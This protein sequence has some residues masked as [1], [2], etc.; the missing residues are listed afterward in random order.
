M[1]R[2]RRRPIPTPL[3]WVLALVCA[4]T[5]GA[6]PQ[7]SQ[8]APATNH[9]SF[10]KQVRPILTDNCYLC[11]GPDKGTRKAGLRLDDRDAALAG[12]KGRRAIVPGNSAASELF[13]R[14]SSHDPNYRM[15]QRE[16]GRSLT[17]KQIALLK[18]WI[19]QGALYEPHWAYVAPQKKTPPPV[20]QTAWVRNPVDAFILSEL[21]KEGL[22]PSPEAD[23][24]TLI[25][26]LNFDLTGLPP[27][28]AEVDAFLA[29]TAPD[30]YEHLVDRLLASPHYG[31]RMAVY[32]LDLVRFA[33]TVGY[34]GDQNVDVWPFRDYVIRAFNDNLPFDQFTREQLAGDLLPNATAQ[35]KV[36]SAYNRLNMV[37]REGGAQAKEY[38]AKY[39]AD[40]VRTT[41]SVWLGSTLGCA[42]CHDHKFDPFSTKDF[43][44]FAAFFADV[45]E[46]GVYESAAFYAA[47]PPVMR[48]SNA[49]QDKKLAALTTQLQQTEKEQALLLDAS[50]DL[51]DLPLAEAQQKVAAVLGVD[52]TGLAKQVADWEQAALERVQRGQE[53]ELAVIIEDDVRGGKKDGQWN[54]VEKVADKPTHSGRR[55]REQ[56]GDGVVQHFAEGFARPQKLQKQDRLYAYVYLDPQNPPAEIMLQWDTGGSQWAHRAY[57]G[58]DLIP[59]GAIGSDAPDHRRL[60]DLPATGQ[61][62]RLEADL[63]KLGFKPGQQLHGLAFTQHGGHVWWDDAG[64]F[65]KDLPPEDVIAVLNKPAASRTENDR[66]LLLAEFFDEVPLKAAVDRHAAAK[67]E[68]AAFDETLP[69]CVITESVEPRVTHVLPRGNWMDDSG[70]V[71]SPAVPHSLPQPDNSTQRRLTRLDL[72]NWLVSRENPLTA[73]VVVN[74]LW[75]LYFGNGLSKVLDDLGTRGEWPRHLDLLDWLAAEFMDGPDGLRSPLGTT[76]RA[77]AAISLSSSG[78]EGR[79]EEVVSTNS[80]LQSTGSHWDLKHMVRLLVTS[81][82]YRQSS[83][84]TEHLKEFDPFNRFHARQS[85]WRLDAE[86]V[87]DNALAISGLLVPTVGGASVNPYQPSDYY[88]ELNFPKRTYTPDKGENQYRRGLY[89][90]W[91]RTFLHPSLG[92]FDAPSREECTAE[93]NVSNSPLQA[94]T[95]LNDPTYVEASRVFAEHILEHGSAEFPQRLHWAYLRALSREPTASEEST[96]KTFFDAQLAAF[97]AHADNAKKLLQTGYAPV[98]E[99]LDATELAAWT[100]VT[101]AI[102]NLH[103][104]IVR[105]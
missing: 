86:F 9:I 50:L 70:E 102:L 68:M 72:A 48:V 19:D 91:Q 44:S 99:K 90:H 33:D 43:Y 42:Q 78:G 14:I 54:L 35:Q 1:C 88:K 82:T 15:P 46:E 30:A 53:K 104:T 37:T 92:A 23:R 58:K 24:R 38:L 94:L 56:S 103:E 55:V 63:Q 71:V 40:R 96:M 39:A 12:V 77:D 29:D 41:S 67:K 34:H 100:E 18:E 5:A 61:W 11:H 84:P 20:K 80:T 76:S 73:R 79:G 2:A 4:A 21:E 8:P 85:R 98:P 97:Q 75:K 59:F 60:G 26:R 6:T 36:A 25:R 81:S 65:S 45:K 57:W 93:R 17:P 32:W 95:L 47:F 51:D 16:S 13:K 69:L 105:F 31:E 87:R 49:G 52:T 66:S 10:N 89:T 64:V 27:S 83:K 62:V 7:P 101:R 28:P 22:A 3:R 74:R